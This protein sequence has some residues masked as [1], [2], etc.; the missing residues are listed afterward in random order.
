MEAGKFGFECW[1][2]E[3]VKGWHKPFDRWNGW[4]MPWLDT[5]SN[6]KIQQATK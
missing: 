6:R 2:G 3:F 5:Y 4:R 1:Q